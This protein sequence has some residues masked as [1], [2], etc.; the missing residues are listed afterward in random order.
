ML[1]RVGPPRRGARA[2]RRRRRGRAPAVRAADL[3]PVRARLA[4]RLRPA[5][6]EGVC[7]RCGGELFQRDDDSEDTIRHRLEVYADQTAPLIGFY[8]DQRPAS[9]RRRTGPVDDVTERAINALR[10]FETEREGRR[11]VPEET[12]RMIQIKTRGRD[13]ASCARPG[14]SS[15]RTLERVPRRRGARRHDRRA[16]RDRRGRRSAGRRRSRRS[17]ATTASPPTI[18]ASVNDEIVHG[19]PGR[20]VLAEG[21]IISIDCGAIV[22]GWHGDAAVTVP[23]GEV[24]RG[25]PRA[26]PG[27]R[28]GHVARAGGRPGR[29]QALRHR[30]TRSR[31]TITLAGRLRDRRG[32]RR[33]RHRHRDAPGAARAQLRPARPRPG[34]A[35]GPGAGGRADGQPGQPAHPRC[36]TTAGP[37]SPPTASARRTSSTPWRSPTT[38]PGC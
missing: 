27:V 33:P 20:R 16:R 34:L 1:D 15:A 10:R 13:R 18:C 21:D 17:W 8:G 36:S 6:H 11:H 31:P 12:E 30:R 7:D 32:V 25:A 29:R 3:P 37:S 38:A 2:R 14:S 28:G 26:D 5:G 9:R 19:I 4:P 23:V 22:D 24:A 35:E